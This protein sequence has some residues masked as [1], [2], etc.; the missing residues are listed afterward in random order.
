MT[1]KV[2]WLKQ[3]SVCKTIVAEGMFWPISVSIFLSLWFSFKEII[4]VKNQTMYVVLMSSCYFICYLF[5]V[6]LLL[7]LVL[8][9][10]SVCCYKAFSKRTYI[11]LTIFICMLSAGCH[12]K[13]LHTWFM[14]NEPKPLEAINRHRYHSWDRFLPSHLLQK[15]QALIW[16]VRIM[17][18]RSGRKVG[19]CI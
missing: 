16:I 6:Y 15:P 3:Y 12:R 13:C 9:R 7:L 19:F 5:L 8:L 10:M 17:R 18:A 4:N 11:N 1:S 14:V 2:F